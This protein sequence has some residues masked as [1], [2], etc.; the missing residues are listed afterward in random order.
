MS[1]DTPIDIYLG[2][3]K[4]TAA[5]WYNAVVSNLLAD[6]KTPYYDDLTALL[7]PIAQYAAAV[8]F[9]KWAH[10]ADADIEP[11]LQAKIDEHIDD[12][13]KTAPLPQ[14]DGINRNAE[15]NM[16][17]NELDICTFIGET[18][19]KAMSH[20]YMEANGYNNEIIWMV[21]E[22]APGSRP[23]FKE[24]AFDVFVNCFISEIWFVFETVV[25]SDYYYHY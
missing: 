25:S 15:D 1:W 21:G 2:T 6:E 20:R 3:P 5:Q 24:S 23:E 12:P 8:T 17:D 11:G 14:D 16:F 4:A 18:A 22:K 10:S 9:V 13:I 19:S 7:L